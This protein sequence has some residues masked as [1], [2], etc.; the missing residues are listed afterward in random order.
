MVKYGQRQRKWGFNVKKLIAVLLIALLALAGLGAT[1]AEELFV[2]QESAPAPAA[3]T[4]SADFE[5][6]PDAPA[7]EAPEPQV[8]E[9]GSLDE[10]AVLEAPE[11]EEEAREAGAVPSAAYG[12]EEGVVINETNF[13]DHRFRGDVAEFD[14]DKSGVLSDAEIAAVTKI[15]LPTEVITGYYSQQ[16]QTAPLE[17]ARSLKGIEFFYNLTSLDCG[18][19]PIGTLDLSGNP[20][21]TELICTECKLTSLDLR[22][23]P[24]LTRLICYRN[25]LTSL[26]LRPCPLLTRLD[27]GQNKI[28]ALDFGPCPK[29]ESVSCGYNQMTEVNLSGHK[30][31]V[32]LACSTNE[33]LTSVNVRGCLKL[34]GLWITDMPLAHLDVTGCQALQWLYCYNCKLTSLDLD[35]CGSLETLSCYGNLFT[36]LDV[37][38]CPVLV[39]AVRNGSCSSTSAGTRYASGGDYRLYCDSGITIITEPVAPTLV[40]D[41]D[42]FVGETYGV[43]GA[44]SLLEASQCDFKSSNDKVVRVSDKGVL[45]GVGKGK[46]TI[47]ATSKKYGKAATCEIT[48]PEPPKKMVLVE[49]SAHTALLA[50]NPKL[51]LAKTPALDKV[52]IGVGET[53]TLE[54]VIPEGTQTGFAWKCASESVLQPGERSDQETFTIRG[55]KVGRCVV[56]V[57][58]SNGLESTCAVT[59]KKAPYN[60]K[61]SPEK[62]KLRIGQSQTLK[63]KL[64]R[65]SASYAAPVWSGSNDAIA[66]SPEGEVTLIRDGYSSGYYTIYCTTYNGIR[67]SCPVEV[68][69]TPERVALDAEELELTIGDTHQFALYYNGVLDTSG[70]TWKSSNSKVVSISPTGKAKGRKKGT[71]TITVTAYNGKS[72]KCKVTVTKASGTLTLSQTKATMGLDER[73]TLTAT[74]PR[75]SKGKVKWSS[76]NESVATVD[77][78]GEVIATGKGSATITAKVSGGGSATCKVTV[79]KAPKSVKLN[80]KSLKLEIGDGATLKA[81]L[82]RG[83]GSGL[84][85][86]TNN[87]W[88]ATVDD[89]GRVKAR[90]DGTATITVKTC[91][92]LTAT[93]QV[94]VTNPVKYRALL[95]YEAH[96]DLHGSPKN[97][98][99]L[100]VKTLK[101]VRGADGGSFTIT[102]KKNPSADGIRDAIYEAFADADDNDVSLFFITTHG[103][104]MAGIETYAAGELSLVGK[105]KPTLPLPKLA[106]WLNAAVP[107]KVIVLLNACGSGA[108]LYQPGHPENSYDPAAQAMASFDAAA[109]RA[110]SGL[111]EG[112]WVDEDG[113]GV[114]DAVVAAN[115]GEVRLANRVYVLTAARHGEKGWTGGSK[116][117]GPTSWFVKWLTDGIGGNMPA[118]TNKDKRVTLGELFTYVSGKSNTT[119]VGSE[120]EYQHVQVY[121]S[122]SDFAMFRKK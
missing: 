117:T 81:T 36:V 104:E 94:T 87:K 77:T 21:L 34:K 106:G 45:T 40:G 102:K 15:Y 16:Y 85:W 67:V 105:D 98:V 112:I 89:Q 86:S 13:P 54:A 71:A 108:A 120:G 52:T 96:S 88:V 38:D 14:T 2:E 41:I 78:Y 121:P 93:C 122:N 11:A 7:D 1:Q 46:A 62:L 99:D 48:V 25:E 74:K 28:S 110:F 31:L 51:T 10:L 115:A 20:K 53:L 37:N 118:D 12:D 6:L 35:G 42:L 82:S 39:D 91:N 92:G 113:Q 116:L 95:I 18:G 101:A 69:S 32:E 9:V 29:L 70:A 83:S 33:G 5:I 72:A 3:D 61:V 50:E 44:D 24:K 79:K 19:H 109:V 119:P 90:S 27:C 64:P 60:V 100:M 111:D 114:S 8:G 49:Q 22:P 58:T 68:L 63:L 73:L 66:V 80:K 43:L 57:R 97:D 23:C 107:G 56:R 103:N 26:D 75:G 17:L 4:D 55:L 76:S 30:A 84:Q 59:V 47:T 65:D